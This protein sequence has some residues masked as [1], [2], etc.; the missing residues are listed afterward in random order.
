MIISFWWLISCCS[1]SNII[2]LIIISMNF[3]FRI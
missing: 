3:W 1:I 2:K